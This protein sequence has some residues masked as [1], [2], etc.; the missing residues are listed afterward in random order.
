MK[1][2]K[3][4]VAL[5]ILSVKPHQKTLELRF[6]AQHTSSPF[7]LPAALITISAFIIKNGQAIISII[8]ALLG[9]AT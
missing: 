1:K 7:N 2:T 9:I 6:K 3:S 5:F 4:M 8:A